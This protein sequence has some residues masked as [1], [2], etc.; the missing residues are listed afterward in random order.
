MHEA[1]GIKHISDYNIMTDIVPLETELQQLPQ[2]ITAWRKLRDESI[3][4]KEQIR[5]R[6]V[7]MKA[8]E[9]VI[10]R[11]MKSNSI[12]ALDLKQSNARLL[13][14]NKET[15]GSLSQKSLEEHLGEF[16]KSTEEAGKAMAYINEK[17]G[18]KKLETLSFEKL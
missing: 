3:D 8:F 14:K 15:K 10:L 2:V 4:L 17:R 18:V 1:T 12:G 5:E 9:G 7:R 11:T 13:F 6:K 16:L